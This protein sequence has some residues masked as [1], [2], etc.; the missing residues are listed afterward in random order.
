MESL[1]SLN[2][3]VILKEFGLPGLVLFLWF[4]SDRTNRNTLRQYRED[5]IAQ[6]EMYEKNVI[7]V[8]SFDSLGR[9]YSQMAENLQDL[10]AANI[11]QLT[12]V[13]VKIDSNQF[14]PMVRQAGGKT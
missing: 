11:Q 3:D 8:Q 10:V 9:S 5:M 1:I 14:C 2:W 13:T 6:R 7:L 12:H 4:L